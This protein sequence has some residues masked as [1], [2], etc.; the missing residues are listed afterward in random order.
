MIFLIKIARKSRHF[1]RYS[2]IIF[3]TY[4]LLILEISIFNSDKGRYHWYFLRKIFSTKVRAARSRFYD[5]FDDARSIAASRSRYRFY[6]RARTARVGVEL[7]GMRVCAVKVRIPGFGGRIIATESKVKLN[8]GQNEFISSRI[9]MGESCSKKG[10]TWTV[11][12]KL[13]IQLCTY[14]S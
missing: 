6:G 1:Y 3:F 2:K 12:S 10:S 11:K 13:I 8:H 9:W 4:S 14:I 5:N 7:F